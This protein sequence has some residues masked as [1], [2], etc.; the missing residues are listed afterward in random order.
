MNTVT[1]KQLPGWCSGKEFACNTGDTDD[2]GLT[3]VRK[4]S[5]RRKQKPTPVFLPGQSHEQRSLVGYSPSGQKESDTT[6]HARMYHHKWEKDRFG[7]KLPFRLD[8]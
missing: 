2:K 7:N 1:Y 6:E 3:Q 8:L 5:W 4:I